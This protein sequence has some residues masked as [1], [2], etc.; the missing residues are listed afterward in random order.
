MVVANGRPL[1]AKIRRCCGLA[2]RARRGTALTL[3]W[4][5]FCLFVMNYGGLLFCG[6]DDAS[7]E[8]GAADKASTISAPVCIL[9]PLAPANVAIVCTALLL[10]LTALLCTISASLFI[11]SPL[12]SSLLFSFFLLSTHPLCHTHTH[13]CHCSILSVK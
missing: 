2:H 6:H 5:L 3:Q 13:A 8:G 9:L 11:F 10:L 7:Q 1:T 12:L 4:F